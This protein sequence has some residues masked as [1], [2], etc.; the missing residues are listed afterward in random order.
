MAENVQAQQENK[1]GILVSGFGWETPDPRRVVPT[2]ARQ[3]YRIHYIL[4]GVGYLKNGEN[5]FRLTAGTGFIIFPGTVPNYHP[6]QEQPWEYFWVKLA[7]EEL[8]RLIEESGLTR[9]APCFRIA[10]MPEE[11]SEMMYNIC[12]AVLIASESPSDLVCCFHSLFQK[13]SPFQTACKNKSQYFDECLHFIHERYRDN[14][15]VMDIA[16]HIAIDRTYL[17]KLFKNNLGLSPQTYLID[18]RISQACRLLRSTEMS[19]SAIA[20]MV[21]FRDFS[22]FSRQFRKRQKITPSQFR[23][24]GSYANVINETVPSEQK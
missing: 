15:T 23:I 1:S 3:Q 5:N 17:Y 19:I 12:H 20:Y 6:D 8:D 22:D 14:I 18:H 13:L 4:D 10:G 11:T 24:V 2:F 9:Q 21:G 16:E 7:G